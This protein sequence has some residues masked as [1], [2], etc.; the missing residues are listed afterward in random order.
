MVLGFEKII[1]SAMDI[2]KLNLANLVGDVMGE[3]VENHCVDFVDKLW[4]I[5]DLFVCMNESNCDKT[6]GLIT[7]IIPA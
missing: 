6:G 5:R 3:I 1:D 7:G 2:D 4:I